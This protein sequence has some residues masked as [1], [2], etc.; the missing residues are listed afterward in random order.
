MAW[1]TVREVFVDRATIHT[2]L[3]AKE[4]RAVSAK[5]ALGDIRLSP[6]SGL[7]V[8]AAPVL[9][10]NLHGYGAPTYR[11]HAGCLTAGQG[12]DSLRLAEPWN[13]RVVPDGHVWQS[14]RRRPGASTACSSLDP[15]TVRR[16][17]RQLETSSCIQHTGTSLFNTGILCRQ[18]CNR[19]PGR[20]RGLH[21]VYLPDRSSPALTR[22]GRE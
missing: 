7:V 1:P 18:R 12:T 3:G 20:P 16:H 8:G 9:C 14:A 6:A 21:A 2:P 15:E 13:P 22:P 4:A 10:S 11:F 17:S 19:P 5:E